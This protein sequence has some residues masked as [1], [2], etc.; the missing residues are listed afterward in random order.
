ME[1]FAGFLAHTDYHLGRLL[2]AIAASP[3]ADNTIVIYVAGDN[4]PS[5]EG[6][7][8]GTTNNMMTQNGVPD[9]VESQLE[10]FDEIGGPLH[11]N[12][13]PLGWCWAGSSPLQWMKRVPSHFGGTC[14]GM[15]VSWP[16]NIKDK[17]GLRSQFHHLID[18]AP[19]VL[20]AANIPEP[21]SVDGID[22]IPMAGVSMQYAFARSDAE[23]KRTKQYI[24]TGGHRA[25]YEDGGWQHPSMAFP[26]S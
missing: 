6:S 10:V 14:N 22:Q 23:G 5:A 11:E 2:D 1:C 25:I 15:I 18:I 7:V 9:S 3:N 20:E 13:Y 16:A 12:H 26:G 8:T 4:G 17:G 19:T 21:T 24:E